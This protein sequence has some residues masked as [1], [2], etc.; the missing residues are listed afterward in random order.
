MKNNTKKLCQFVNLNFIKLYWL[1]KNYIG[2]QQKF[3]AFNFCTFAA[4]F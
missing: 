4:H 2:N 1:V 3:Y